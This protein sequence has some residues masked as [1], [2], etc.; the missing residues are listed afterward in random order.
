MVLAFCAVCDFVFFIGWAARGADVRTMGL[1]R[2]GGARMVLGLG[3]RVGR[4]LVRRVCSARQVLYMLELLGDWQ[5]AEVGD[6][7]VVAG[8]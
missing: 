6:S 5:V 7:M 1:P 3:E 4:L 2:W 8:M